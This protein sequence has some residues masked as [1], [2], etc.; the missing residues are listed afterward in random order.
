MH[1]QYDRMP[2]MHL[3]AERLVE[4]A[5]RVLGPQASRADKYVYLNA[6]LSRLGELGDA[7]RRARLRVECYETLFE[8]GA[9]REQHEERDSPS[10]PAERELCGA[11]PIESIFLARWLRPVTRDARSPR[12]A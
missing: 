10:G 8:Q 6:L 7:Q 5:G 1:M 4:M 12:A 3:G 9:E 11:G 2:R